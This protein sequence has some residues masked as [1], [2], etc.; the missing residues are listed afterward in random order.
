MPWYNELVPESDKVVCGNDRRVTLFGDATCWW[1]FND[2]GNIHTDT[3]GEPI[4]MEIRAQAFC[5][6]TSDEINRMTFYNYELINKG[7]Q[8]LYNTYFA[9]YLDADLGFYNE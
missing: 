1:I 9:Q 4:G 6:S 3:G 5:F 7:T 8:T 2:K